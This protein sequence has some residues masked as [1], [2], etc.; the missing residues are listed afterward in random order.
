VEKAW[1]ALRNRLRACVWRKQTCPDQYAVQLARPG[2]CRSDKQVK[3][4]NSPRFH[5]F[6]VVKKSWMLILA[7][8]GLPLFVG[9]KKAVDQSRSSDAIDPIH[10]HLLHALPKLPTIKL[11]AGDQEL[12][13][14]IARQSVEIATGM[15]FRTNMAENEAMLFVFP[16]AS[17]KNFYMRNCLL[18]LSAAYITPDGTI[19][20]IVDLVP[21][22]EQGVQS[23]SDNIQF[24]L[25]VRQGWF[26]RHNLSTGAV[27]RTERGPLL[28]TFYPRR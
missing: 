5:Q 1:A 19:S 3:V 24:V 10:G 21:G 28:Q 16:E 18:P 17:P 23:R 2:D 11:W 20:E 26:Q 7:L 27:V 25:E 4:E 12:V 14:E 13:A 22:D 9:C 8:S 6:W 15:M